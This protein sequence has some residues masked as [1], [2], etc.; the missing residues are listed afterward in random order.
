MPLNE[1]VEEIIWKIRTLDSAELAELKTRLDSE[2]GDNLL[3]DQ[4][5]ELST[6]EPVRTVP[7]IDDVVK[8]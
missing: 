7:S 6:R 2:W 4:P 5:D 3:P 8:T 1:R